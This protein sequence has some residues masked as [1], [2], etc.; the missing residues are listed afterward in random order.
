MEGIHSY[1]TVGWLRESVS[2]VEYFPLQFLKFILSLVSC[3]FHFSQPQ[4]RRQIQYKRRPRISLLT[5]SNSQGK[6][7]A[8]RISTLIAKSTPPNPS[9]MKIRQSHSKKQRR[10]KEN[11]DI[12]RTSHTNYVL[13][14]KNVRTSHVTHVV[15]PYVLTTPTQPT[16]EKDQFD[17][18]SDAHQ[19]SQTPLHSIVALCAK[20]GDC[21]TPPRRQRNVKR[22]SRRLKHKRQ[23]RQYRLK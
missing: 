3:F 19:L 18:V 15:S 13:S 9:H 20:T 16:M 11:R 4:N 14:A 6:K 12:E 1:L 10:K 22:V 8:N 17:T 2:H 21:K 7:K 5:Q 23:T